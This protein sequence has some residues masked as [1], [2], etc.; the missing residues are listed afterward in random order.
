MFD[1]SGVVYFRYDAPEQKNNV[2]YD[3]YWF[4]GVH[5]NISVDEEYCLFQEFT[6]RLITRS[7]MQ[8]NWTK[9]YRCHNKVYHYNNLCLTL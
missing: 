3:V 6:T 1:I 7:Y 8:A 4:D 9:V 2:L 5:I